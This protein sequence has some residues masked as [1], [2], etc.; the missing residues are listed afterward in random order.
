MVYLIDTYDSLIQGAYE[1]KTLEDFFTWV[2]DKEEIAVDTETRGKDPHTKEIVCLQIGDK[3]TQWVIDTR[4]I[5]IRIFK[6]VLESRVCL[7]HNSK[8]DYKFLK[9][10]GILLNKIYDTMLAEC[11]IYAGYESWGY[12]LDK[13]TARYLDIHLSKDDRGGFY[14]YPY[15][16]PYTDY[17]IDYAAKDVAYLHLIREKQMDLINKYNL[18]YC[19]DLENEVVKALGDIEYNGVYL[20]KDKWL[21]NASKNFLDMQEISN[22]LDSIVLNEPLLASFV[23]KY[24]QSDLF[25]EER[26]RVNINYES[27][28]QILKIL[29]ALGVP[30]DDTQD[31]TLQ[32]NKDLHIFISK[33]QEFRAKAKIASTYG[34]SFLKYVNPNTN[35]VHTSFWQIVSTGRLS[36]GNKEDNAPNMQN[37]PA[38]KEFRSC[39]EAREGYL[40]IGC[41]YSGQ[42]LCLMADK[43]GEEVFINALN[44]DEDLHSISASMLFNKPITKKDKVERTAAKTITFG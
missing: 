11:I 4:Q 19:L 35:K 17:M 28:S 10:K 33:L 39:F 26:R 22:D 36:S 41:D 25:G 16:V 21:S 3:D 18:N 13:L 6:E 32:K 23:P 7:L 44:N 5:D 12:G 30:E 8:F 27:P 2:K 38:T 14:N 40:W 15:G 42:E 1:K 37:I 34:E 24:V 31:R 29:K 43:S 20:N 9:H